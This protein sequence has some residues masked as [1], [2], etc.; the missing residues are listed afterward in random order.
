[1]KPPWLP[2]AAGVGA[3]ALIAAVIGA[4]KPVEVDGHGQ[5][6]RRKL[7]DI[8]DRAIAWVTRTESGGNYGAQNKNLDG[9]GLSYGLLQWTQR[10]GNLGK[11]LLVMQRRDEPAFARIFAPDAALLIATTTAADEA[12]RMSLRLWEA[13]WTARFTAA[14]LHAPFHE[15]QD[16]AARA[17]EHWQGAVDVAGV[18]G[19]STE[20]AM[21]LFFDRAVQQ[22][23][24][25]VVRVA[26][27]LKADLIGTGKPSVPYLDLL[28]AFSAR[29]ALPFRH[30]TRPAELTTTSGKEWRLVGTEWHLFAGT[31]DL[32]ATIVQRTGKILT[33]PSLSD[34][35]DDRAVA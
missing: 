9:A 30:A 7:M 25:A 23:P 15:A 11:L 22:G 34:G 29:C 10:S 24:V 35:M 32:Y 33:D 12:K 26:Q 18:L 6:H 14:G 16:A 13:P 17:S 20:R 3:M 27:K 2:I 4:S 8:A 1:M 19:V 31:F 5:P 21:V 28:R